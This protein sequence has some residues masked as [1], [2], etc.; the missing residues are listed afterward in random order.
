[1]EENDLLVVVAILALIGGSWM[2]S[3]YRNYLDTKK[4]DIDA[5]I[6]RIR[7]KT[8]KELREEKHEYICEIMALKGENMEM[9][10]IDQT[11]E[12]KIDTL[13]M[14]EEKIEEKIE[15]YTFLKGEVKKA[16]LEKILAEDRVKRDAK[17][18]NSK[19]PNEDPNPSENEN[20]EIPKKPKNP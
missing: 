7:D 6:I 11:L 13:R 17:K 14:W 3:Y 16:N 15:E 10:Q 5:Q 18:N 20:P 19:K 2:M 12:K 9:K 1:M 4:P 8:I